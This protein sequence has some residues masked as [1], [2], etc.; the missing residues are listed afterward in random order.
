MTL[1]RNDFIHL[2]VA[3]AVW[4]V[5][6]EAQQP[7]TPS[8]PKESSSDPLAKA[9]AA[10]NTKL[11]DP[12]S[13]RYGPMVRKTGPAINGKPAEVVCGSVNEKDTLGRY[14]GNRA[15]VY[16]IADGVTFLVE[17]RPQPEDIAQIIHGRFCK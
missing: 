11:K 14:G 13:A 8:A 9:M 12:E 5:T 15:F 2:V 16:F 7:A 17:A 3:L 4:P 1:R 6:A 10:V